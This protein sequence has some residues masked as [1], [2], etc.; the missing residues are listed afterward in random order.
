MDDDGK[1][2]AEEKLDALRAAGKTNIWNG[3][4]LGLDILR[5]T[6]EDGMFTHIML[7][8]DGK[9]SERDAIVPNLVEYK[10]KYGLPC[11][12]NTYGFGYNRMVSFLML[13]LWALCL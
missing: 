6:E 2:E 9:S 10:A 5:S 1:A 11:S 4:Q 13:A 8:T 7:L 12:I 3:L